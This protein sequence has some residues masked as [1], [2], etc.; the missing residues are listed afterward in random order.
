MPFYPELGRH[1]PPPPP[2]SSSQRNGSNVITTLEASQ[3]LNPPPPPPPTLYSRQN[4]EFRVPSPCELEPTVAP[5]VPY[6]SNSSVAM[7]AP[8]V[9]FQGAAT[10]PLNPGQTVDYPAGNQYRESIRFGI[11]VEPNP[12]SGSRGHPLRH[13]HGSSSEG[14]SDPLSHRSIVHDHGIVM[15]SEYDAFTSQSA[16]TVSSSQGESSDA[17]KTSPYGLTVD[18]RQPLPILRRYSTT[19]VPALSYPNRL[20]AVDAV[21]IYPPSAVASR[22]TVARRPTLTA[23]STA[24]TTSSYHHDASPVEHYGTSKDHTAQGHE[25][26]RRVSRYNARRPSASIRYEPYKRRQSTIAGEN[27]EQS[28]VTGGADRDPVKDLRADSD[29]EIEERGRKGEGGH[30][31]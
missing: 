9:L 17:I 26:W 27:V 15:K 11:P 20:D 10:Q 23:V 25:E 21:D 29:V 6:V 14:R 24:T 2:Y 30:K 8:P 19:T 5:R 7:P 13:F 16:R 22:Q 12:V 18:D 4:K 3:R 1:T 28:R 31:H